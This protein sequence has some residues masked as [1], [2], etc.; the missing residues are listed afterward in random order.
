MHFVTFPADIYGFHSAVL[1]ISLVGGFFVL[2]SFALICHIFWMRKS[3]RRVFEFRGGRQ[4]VWTRSQRS[5]VPYRRTLPSINHAYEPPH[6]IEPPQSDPPPPIR[7]HLLHPRPKNQLPSDDLPSRNPTMNSHGSS[8]ERSQTNPIPHSV[9]PW[10]NHAIHEVLP[11][12]PQLYSNIPHLNKKYPKVRHAKRPQ[13]EPS[14]HQ[15][16]PE[17]FSYEDSSSSVPYFHTRSYPHLYQ[18]ASGASGDNDSA[19]SRVNVPR[20]PESP[21]TTI[22]PT[23]HSGTGWTL[24]PNNNHLKYEHSRIS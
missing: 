12:P 2:A 18:G 10:R 19:H 21:F 16:Q 20:T 7:A 8:E 14:I 5:Q 23:Y 1:G 6:D 9:P 15:H 17:V 13:L 4:E 11:E 3:S 22:N 24:H